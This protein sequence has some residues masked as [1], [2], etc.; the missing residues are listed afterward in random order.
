MADS[1]KNVQSY[2]LSRSPRVVSAVSDSPSHMMRT[3]RVLRGKWKLS[4]IKFLQDG[5]KRFGELRRIM[6]TVTQAM[7]TNHL[8]ELESDG[9]I[10]RKVYYQMPLKVEYSLT[11]AGKSI[12]PIMEMME[13]WGTKHEQ[14]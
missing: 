6:P 1:T 3:L 11:E 14:N 8:R 13:Q 2:S 12:I 10:M 4:I 9:I 7:L 5:E